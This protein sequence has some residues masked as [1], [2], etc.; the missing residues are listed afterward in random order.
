[1]RNILETDSVIG[2]SGQLQDIGV[3]DDSDPHSFIRH[4]LCAF[5]GRSGRGWGSNTVECSMAIASE[6]SL[7]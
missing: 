2:H 3:K 5:A 6:E 4:L 7:V 1:M